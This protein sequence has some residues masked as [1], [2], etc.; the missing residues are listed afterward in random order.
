MG[1]AQ[2]D[3]PHLFSLAKSDVVA[4]ADS[5]TSVATSF[6]QG[7][8]SGPLSIATVRSSSE[9]TYARGATEPVTKTELVLEGGRAGDLTFGFGPKGLQVAGQGIPIPQ[10]QGLAALNQALAPA[11]MSIRFGEPQN[12]RG[13]KSAPAF[14]IT[15]TGD[16]PGAGRGTMRVRLGGASSYVVPGAGSDVA[17]PVVEVPAGNAPIEPSPAAPADGSSAPAATVAASTSGGSAVPASDELTGPASGTARSDFSVPTADLPTTSG[18]PSAPA[19]SDLAAGPGTSTEAAALPASRTQLVIRPRQFGA[20]FVLSLLFPLA[21]G[22]ALGSVVIW[23]RTR[24][25]TQWTS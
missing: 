5:V 8:S 17:T 3:V 14:E 12:L 4:T 21:G 22:A 25:L 7:F 2:P 23:R 20:P 16:V 11:K 6:T 9:T 10:D 1:P 13:G 18:D 19:P 15:S 24:R